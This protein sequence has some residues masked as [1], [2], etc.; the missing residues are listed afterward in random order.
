M[1]DTLEVARKVMEAFNCHD[2][3]RIAALHT[4]DAL[5]VAPPD[6]EFRGRAAVT[7]YAMV[8]LDGFP[9]AHIDVHDETVA[10][11][12][13]IIQFT[14]R[15]TH[16]DTLHSPAG[17]IP[18]TGKTLTCRGVQIMTISGD[19]VAETQLYY[20]QLDLITQLGLTPEST[21]A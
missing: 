12:K 17:N 6:I 10:G 14:F 19:Q 2:P 11:N 9:D 1:A 16:T 18:A 7:G 3:D 4:I 21:T 15:G 20:D 5:T 8:W 13:A